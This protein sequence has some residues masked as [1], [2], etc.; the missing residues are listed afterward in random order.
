LIEFNEEIGVFNFRVWLITVNGIQIGTLQ[1]HEKKYH[2]D[3]FYFKREFT[4]AQ[5]GN[6]KPVIELYLSLLYFGITSPIKEQEKKD[7]KYS[8]YRKFAIKE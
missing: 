6:I 2:L 5:K 7:F 1:K 8:D 4:I 3:I